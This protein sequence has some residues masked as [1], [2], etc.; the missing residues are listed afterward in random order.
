MKL[1]VIGI[2]TEKGRRG[3]GRTEKMKGKAGMVH[4]RLSFC[5][6]FLP[7]LTGPPQAHWCLPRWYLSNI[8]YQSHC[9]SGAR[10]ELSLVKTQGRYLR[11]TDHQD[12]KLLPIT[13]LW[14]QGNLKVIFWFHIQEQNASFYAC[15]LN[16]ED[17]TMQWIASLQTF[18]KGRLLPGGYSPILP[19]N[20]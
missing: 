16:P 20:L 10:S 18:I 5:S 6:S 19:A 15:P 1:G 4:L 12:P 3:D 2:M 17:L 7:E 8:L 14:F 13:G 11:V 9:Q